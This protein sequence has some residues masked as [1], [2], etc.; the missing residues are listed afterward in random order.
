MKERYLWIDFMKCI[1]AFCIVNSH[2]T[3]LWPNSALAVG[4]AI[5]NSIFFCCSGYL[6]TKAS[7][8]LRN[9]MAKKI[10]RL[11]VPL[12]MV[13]IVWICIGNIEITSLQDFWYSFIWP[14]E[15]WFIQAIL[16]SYVLLYYIMNRKNKL[17]TINKSI[18]I[19][20]AFYFVFYIILLMNRTFDVEGKSKFKWI[21]YFLCMLFG[22]KLRL[23]EGKEQKCIKD[24]VKILLASTLIYLASKLCI[25][26]SHWG[27]YYQFIYQFA[28]L[29]IA[30]SLLQLLRASTKYIESIRSENIRRI[31]NE[32]G[33]ATL[34]IYLVNYVVIRY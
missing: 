4:G 29:G 30:I 6:G 19:C 5:G 11:Y 8:T 27:F 21:F 9:Y 23:T 17:D 10:I 13:S 1:A 25:S 12:W 7:G 15:Y 33:G 2:F 34:E 18:L 26:R 20:V 31:I 16:L 28:T 24:F 32:I 14:K 22:A 3:H